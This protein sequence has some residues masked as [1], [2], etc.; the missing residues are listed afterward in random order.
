M[1]GAAMPDSP[2]LAKMKAWL[3]RA[4]ELE[5]ATIPPYMI[6]LLSI[7]LPGNR[8]VAEII[9]GVMIEEMLHMVLVS[10][11]LNAIGG[12]PRLDS[13]AVPKYPLK[14]TFDEKKQQ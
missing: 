5:L 7:K 1:W 10:N 11:V 12:Q 8:E 14:L 13:T 9:R 2:E 4:L 3:Q 6:C